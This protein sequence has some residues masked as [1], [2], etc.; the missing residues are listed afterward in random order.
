M[1]CLIVGAGA[2]GQV[3]GR[4][5]QAGGADVS[6]LVKEK[7]ADSVRR[8]F[9]LYPLNQKEA[10]SNPVC[11]DAFTVM[12][13]TQDV[14]A[15]QWDYIFLGTSS[16]A[17]RAGDWF[18][19]LAAV[20]GAAMVV[21]LTVGLEDLAFVSR[22][23]AAER[24]AT[25]LITMM[26]YAAPLPGENV[27]RPGTAYWFPPLLKFS[28]SGERKRTRVIVRLL[29]RGG[30]PSALHRNVQLEG[31]MGS[32]LLQTAIYALECS[33]WSLK[34]LAGN[35]ELLAI[36]RKA[37]IEAS[38]IGARKNHARRPLARLLIPGRAL[39]GLMQLTQRIAPLDVERFFERH[40]TKVR[41]QS[42]D[43]LSAWISAGRELSIKTPGLE[44]L[45]ERL[46]AGQVR[47][48]ERI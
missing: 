25:G 29:N 24:I 19:K 27:V 9:T 18:S 15:R 22:Y 17:L 4:H 2:V 3:Y 10:R 14:A 36:T 41:E 1:K 45:Q 35:G 21:I 47:V 28:F 43:M 39:V 46:A 7:Y 44:A 13:D 11:F 5:L 31:A 42:M 26:S 38:Y 48:A 6:F 40:Y 37:M 30:M 32:A 23:V 33:G 12:T 34:N 20:S 16:T 8:G